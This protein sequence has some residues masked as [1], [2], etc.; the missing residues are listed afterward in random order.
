MAFDMVSFGAL[1][2]AAR[3]ADGSF[4]C[5][6]PD[7]WR[8]GRTAYGGFT[9]AVAYNAARNIEA[10]LPPLRSAQ[11]AFIGPVGGTLHARATM[12]RRGK[13]SAF[14]EAR[15]TSDGELAM[16]GTFLFMAERPSP[17]NLAP[18][19]APNVPTPENAEPAMRG[20]GPA[21]RSQLE[22]RHAAAVQDRGKPE[23][24]RWVRLREREGI[25]LASEL[26]L[27][28][29]ALPAGILPLFE[30]PP[31][32]SSANW[33]MHVHG[34]DIATHDGWWL[35]QAKAES[36]LG[37][38]SNQLMSVWNRAGKAVLSSSQTVSYFPSSS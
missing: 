8:Q 15:V 35:V 9:A 36:A 37:G 3:Q 22:F 29:D 34:A 17:V 20:K 1:I 4:A 27:I 18:P 14:V 38:I 30:I 23:L 7:S 5:N 21:Y 2:S 16:L 28:A 33:T 6:L 11:I 26:L 10:Q 13:S 32:I 24:L 19:A 25:D 12:L 31:I